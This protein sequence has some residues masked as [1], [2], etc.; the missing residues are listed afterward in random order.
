MAAAVAA[1]RFECGMVLKDG[2]SITISQQYPPVPLTL[3]LPFCILLMSHPCFTVTGMS[4]LKAAASSAALQS[5]Q[6]PSLQR[7]LT[8]RYLQHVLAPISLSLKAVHAIIL[9]D[10]TGGE[11]VLSGNINFISRVVSVG[12]SP[13]CMPSAFIA[14]NGNVT[15]SAGSS[16]QV[17]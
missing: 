6:L 10:E 7:S 1:A 5:A 2:D 17:V 15:T 3:Q 4:L 16:I 12:Y 9:D 11:I 14:T 8:L 13:L